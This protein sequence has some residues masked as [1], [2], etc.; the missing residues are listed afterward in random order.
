MGLFFGGVGVAT[1]ILPGLALAQSNGW[2]A[3]TPTLRADWVNRVIAAG[4]VVVAVAAVWFWTVIGGAL[5]F[6]EWF[7]ASLVLASYGAAL[8]GLA[9]LLARVRVPA[10]GAAAITVVLGLAWL[11][12]PVWM[13]PWLQGPSREQTVAW[14]VAGHPL[15]A[16]NGSLSR[17]FPVP[18]AQ[19]ALAYRLTNIGDDIIY[20]MPRSIL[21]SVG[22]HLGLAIVLLG[23]AAGLDW[24][25]VFRR[26]EPSQEEPGITGP[27]GAG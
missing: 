13:A 22:V 8:L 2:R 5:S 12:W 15:F 17:V 4:C 20:E 1:I 18:W 19:Y 14:L 3:S 21:C 9:A 6:G 10:A 24:R 25:K 7:R 27:A 11:S 26:P 23:V 16:I